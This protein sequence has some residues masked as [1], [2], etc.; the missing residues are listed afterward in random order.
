MRRIT[1]PAVLVVALVGLLALGRAAGIG[2]QDATPAPAMAGH[3]LVGS[4]IVTNPDGTPAVAAFTAD[5]IVVDTEVGG[6]TGVGT[7]QPTG[8]RTAAFT[9]VIPVSDPEFAGI[10]VVRA[11]AEV[12]AD[13]TTF[14]APYS[15]TGQAPDG[16][17]PFADRGQVTGTRLPVEPIEAA[18]T[19][20]AGFPTWTPEEGGAPEATPAA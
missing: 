16:T 9:F 1:L 3:P 12:S 13:G 2:A 7:W 15:V 8:D 14:T 4:W 19:P 18:G 5:G 17:A 6:G 11:T 20:L 10:I